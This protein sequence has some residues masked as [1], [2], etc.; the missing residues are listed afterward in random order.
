MPSASINVSTATSSF[1]SITAIVSADFLWP[2]VAAVIVVAFL[3]TIVRMLKMALEPRT[4]DNSSVTIRL[5]PLRRGLRRRRR[6]RAGAPEGASPDRSSRDGRGLVAVR[7]V[8]CSTIGM[9]YIAVVTA[10][11]AL[12]TLLAMVFALSPRAPPFR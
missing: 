11:I 9:R 2:V 3:Y 5:S 6:N 10:C 7:S 1:P 4:A 8:G 12:L